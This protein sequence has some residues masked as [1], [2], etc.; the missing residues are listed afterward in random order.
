M[1]IGKRGNALI[2]NSSLQNDIVRE[3]EA[4]GQRSIVVEN[5]LT[6]MRVRWGEFATITLPHQ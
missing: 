6:K 3:R 4:V 1:I 2:W 5:G